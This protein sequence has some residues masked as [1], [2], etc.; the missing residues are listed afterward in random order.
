MSL[1]NCEFNLLLTWSANRVIKSSVIDQVTTFAI[2][3][4]QI[5]V[6]F[7]TLSTQDDVKLLQQLK[8]G[9]TRTNIN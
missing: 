3:D 1:N 7:V 9:F 5:Y 2:T 8:S 6:L 4:T